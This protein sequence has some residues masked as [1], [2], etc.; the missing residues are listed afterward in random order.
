MKK[1]RGLV[2]VVQVDDLTS[3]VPQRYT[4]TRPDSIRESNWMLSERSGK[5]R[6]SP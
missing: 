1:M 4:D 5:K 6:S 3:T 2:D